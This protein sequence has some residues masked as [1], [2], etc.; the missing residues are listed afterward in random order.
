[1]NITT[2]IQQHAKDRPDHLAFILPRRNLKQ[3]TTISFAVLEGIVCKTVND[4]IYK[5]IVP[6]MRVLLMVKPGFD[7]IITMLALLRMGA[8]PIVI[9][10]SMPLKNL[11]ACIRESKPVACVSQLTAYCFAKIYSN[12]FKSVQ[13][14]V[15]TPKLSL[16]SRSRI[17]LPVIAEVFQAKPNDLAAVVFT[18]GSTGIPK[19]VRYTHA[20][21]KSQIQLIAD[22]YPAERTELDLILLPIFALWNPVMGITSLILPINFCKPARI[23]P[24]YLTQAINKFGVTRSFGSPLIWDH[25]SHSCQLTKTTLVSIKRILIAG[26]PVFPSLLRILSEYAP[27]ADIEVPYGATEGLPL[28]TIKASYILEHTWSKTLQGM[29]TC[30]GKSLQGIRLQ[31]ISINHSSRILDSSKDVLET[32]SIGEIIVQGTTV[33]YKYDSISDLDDKRILHSESGLWARMG[34]LGYLDAEGNVWLCGRKVE[35][36]ITRTHSYYPICCEAT[37]NTHPKVYRSAL[38]GLKTAIGL[39]PAIVIEPYPSE[40]PKTQSAQVELLRQIQGQAPIGSECA[41][42]KH[43][44]VYK[45]FPVDARHNAK[46]HRLTLAD[47]FNSKQSFT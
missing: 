15:L 18:S 38:I 27:N 20:L 35:A 47:Y 32:N 31:I 4:F 1:M 25:I 29:G 10:A 23:D 14:H 8:I 9:D 3:A 44:F 34:D 33:A 42:I 13:I 6:E 19:G 26:A 37:Y 24:V 22:T 11:L 17:Q 2:C 39:Q 41:D 12:A 16:H 21:L 7:L 46:I 36:V 5:G 30:V 28:T 45:Q 40:Y 43:F